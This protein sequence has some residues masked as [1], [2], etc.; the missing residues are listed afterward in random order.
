[1]KKKKPI[2]KR[3]YI[4][5]MV[6]LSALFLGLFGRLAYIMVT[7]S[8]KYK[9]I[10]EDQHTIDIQISAKRGRILDRNS[11]ELAIN[12]DIYRID[13]DLNTLRQTLS[14]SK[15]SSSQLADKLSTILN[16]KSED[17]LK[18]LNTTLPSGLPANS[19][20]LKRQIE[21]TL[22]DQVKALKIR[23]IVISSDTKRYYTNGD[24]MT[25]VLGLV[26]YE[27][28]GISGVELSYD[29]EL[30]GTPGSTIYEKDARSNQL[31]YQSPKTTQPTAGKDIILTIDSNIQQFAEKAA[32]KA[33]K[34]NKAKAVNIIVMNPQNGE[35]LAM[36]NKPSMDLNNT[37]SAANN[38]KAVGMLWKNPSVQDNFE[39]GSIFKVITAACALENNIGLNDAYTCSG[40][41]KV[42]GTIMHC[43]DLNGHG[44]ESF[45]DIIKNSCNV[46]FAELGSKLG[47]DKLIATSKKMGFGQATGIDLPGES[48]GILRSPANTNNVDLAALSFGQ[49]VAV[50]Q[51]QYMAAFNA[52]A[53][54]GTWIRPHIMQGIAHIGDSNSEVVDKKYDDYGKKTVYDSNLASQLRQDLVKVVSEGVA[55]NAF[56]QGLDIAGKTGT[57]QITDPATGK[58]APGKYMSS[59]AGMAPAANPKITILI[60]VNEPSGSSYYAGD[61]SAPV[62]KVMFQQI[63]N[64][65]ALKGENN[66]LK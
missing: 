24:F 21:K 6:L 40:S 3:R 16:M 18:I 37:S 48:T 58:Y 57:A 62:A 36:A 9:S 31:P 11:S 33:L 14:D 12:E 66:V 5:V 30:S 61:V 56:V 41:I 54:G 38:P 47:K 46:G 2:K 60:S 15:M 1:M 13:L 39:P 23:G 8:S 65:I 52:I 50:N 44:S 55:K 28:K 4:T 29:K 32:E 7:M 43:W 63:F 26:N 53:N 10:A 59:F 49:G 51:V 42:D 35:I 20:L 64:Y 22:I 17:I 27:G 25:S 19:A 45:V 34:D